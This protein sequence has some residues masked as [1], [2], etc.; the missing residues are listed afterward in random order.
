MKIEPTNPHAF[1][2]MFS[3]HFPNKALL[4]YRSRMD[5]RRV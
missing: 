3:F 5:C 4:P 2:G 1:A